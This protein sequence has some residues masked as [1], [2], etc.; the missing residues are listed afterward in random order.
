MLSFFEDQGQKTV[1]IHVSNILNKLHLASRTQATPY[2]LREGLA[3]L[4]SDRFEPKLITGK[5]S[6]LIHCGANL[7]SQ[8]S[9]LCWRFACPA[10]QGAAN[11]HTFGQL[12]QGGSLFAAIQRLRQ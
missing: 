7:R 2:A 9:H 6:N 12:R 5:Q 4:D 10:H 3:S 11:N 8:Q 1:R